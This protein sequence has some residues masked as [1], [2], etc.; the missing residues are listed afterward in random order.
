MMTILFYL[1]RLMIVIVGTQYWDLMVFM[2]LYPRAYKVH[3][4]MNQPKNVKRFIIGR[5]FFA[6]LANFLLQIFLLEFIQLCSLLE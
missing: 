1:E 5:Q 6:V 2:E 4:L 3:R